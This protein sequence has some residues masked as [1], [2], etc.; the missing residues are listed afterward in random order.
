MK[1]FA[2]VAPGAIW[3]SLIALTVLLAEW[4]TAQFNLVAW[5]PILVG[6][7]TAVLVPFLRL[8]A[9]QDPALAGGGAELSAPTRTKLS[10]WLW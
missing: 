9:A 1:A 5:M 2:G 7:L 4:L 8:L 10:L 3:A 6:F